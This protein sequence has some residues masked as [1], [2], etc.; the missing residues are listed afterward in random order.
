MT[1][2][3]RIV[4][5]VEDIKGVRVTC[6]GCERGLVLTAGK[7]M[8][9]LTECPWCGQ[10]WKVDSPLGHTEWENLRMLLGAIATGQDLH[11][12][13]DVRFEIDGKEAHHEG[14]A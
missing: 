13:I 4:F 12:R 9:V 2:E 5:S 6:K 3:T 8:K 7:P 10:D 11:S 1:R 14:D